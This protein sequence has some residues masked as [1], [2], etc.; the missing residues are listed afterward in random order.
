MGRFVERTCTEVEDG[1]DGTREAESRPLAEFRDCSAYV[2]LGAPGAGK[3]EA[4]KHEAEN[5][6][7]CDAR[8][9]LTLDHKRWAGARTLFIDGLDEVRAGPVDGRSPLDAMRGQ[10]DKLGR[11]RFRLSCREA[12]WFHAA[13]RKRLESVSPDGTVK[14]L[15]LD[16]LS[17]D[18]I[19]DILDDKGTDDDEGTDE[20]DRFVDE[21]RHRGLGALLSNPQT[22]KLLAAAV[23]GGN[24][25]ATRTD[26]FEVACSKLIRELN[27]EHLQAVPQRPESEILRAAGHLCAVQLLSGQAGYRLPIRTDNVDGYIEVRDILE[28]PQETLLAAL[29]TKVFDVTD[30]LA[31]PIH[32]HIA[33]FL[34]GR[35][36]SALI[37]G[38]LSARRVLALLVGDD[39]RTVSGLRGLAAWLAAH[40]KKARD[41]VVERDPL[42][43]VLYGDVKTFSV[44]GKRRLLHLLEQDAERD[45]RVLYAMHD[46]DS[47]WE[48]LATPDM[49]HGFREILTA[50]GG[51]Q[52]RQTVAFAVLRS[53][54]RGAAIPR[55]IPRLLDFVR[56]SKCWPS[57]REAALEA[58]IQQNINGG[59]AADHELR[60]LLADVYA[61]S[62]TDPDDQLLG[63]L[64]MRLFPDTLP[65]AEVG[66]FLRERKRQSLIGQY[67]NFWEDGLVERSTDKQFADAL[68]SIVETRDGRALAV[69]D[70]ESSSFWLR[71]LPGNLLATYLKRS[72]TVRQEQLFEWLGLAAADPSQ[73]AEVEI[74]A[75]LTD[76]PDSYKAV[77]R[78]AADRYPDPSDLAH[79]LDSRLFL[80]FEPSD[81]AVWCLGEAAKAKKNTTAASEFFLG[82]AVALQDEQQIAA[83]TVEETLKHA[84]NVLAR[85]KALRRLRN[86]GA[87]RLE[88]TLD[89][90]EQ[91][92]Q[93]R[94][95][96]RTAAQEELART[97]R[98][99]RTKTTTEPSGRHSLARFGF[100]LPGHV[101]R[102][103]RRNRAT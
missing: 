6:A 43:T 12:D 71:E 93:K 76:N 27:E 16:P 30:G 101:Q 61:G 15:R 88:S 77:V 98:G 23:D 85:H 28:P 74:G 82:R 73:D 91:H 68:D 25:P 36:L 26:T 37:E 67:A 38:H 58:Y 4:F 18:N 66:R 65:P 14:V 24:W 42:G 59:D 22:L 89:A 31:T 97:R 8:D 75:W 44:D 49:E 9:F 40:S 48:G 83:P 60:T 54:E 32:R 45:P 80:A 29:R 69:A 13:D 102:P 92:R 63:L 41:D 39:G 100:R 86:L 64:L 35:Y 78:L 103:A 62:V 95:A 56:D 79:E 99:S 55:L 11:P 3:T 51:S 7:S 33:E 50:T 10:L 72:P 70:N 52:G 90:K 81:F 57:V 20:I 96:E 46:L 34:A 94:E 21:A 47:R 5:E 19:R 53:L 2:L 87:S 17:E 1:T 84:P